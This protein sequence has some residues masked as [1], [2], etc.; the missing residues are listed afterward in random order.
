MLRLL[1][2]IVTAIFISTKWVLRLLRLPVTAAL[3]FWLYTVLIFSGW[4][5]RYVNNELKRAWCLP[6]PSYRCYRD[7]SA[8]PPVVRR[9]FT[10]RGRI[11]VTPWLPP[12]APENNYEGELDEGDRCD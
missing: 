6:L 2:V 5:H 11:R 4:Q 10:M 8:D 9:Y 7:L 12:S 1:S 3:A